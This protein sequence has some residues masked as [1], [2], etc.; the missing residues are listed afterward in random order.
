MAPDAQQRGVAVVANLAPTLPWKAVGDPVRLRQIVTNLLSNAAKFTQSGEVM[1]SAKADIHDE[2][3]TWLFL[4]VKDTGIGIPQEA[5][6]RIFDAFSQE[7]GS[8]TRRYGGTGLGLAIVRELL[9]AMGGSIEL[10]SIPGLG[11][12]FRLALPLGLAATGRDSGLAIDPVHKPSRVELRLANATLTSSIQSYLET[13]QVPCHVCAGD[14]GN[15]Q[16]AAAA[17]SLSVVDY[18]TLT[19]ACISKLAAGNAL[20]GGQ[21]TIVL[22]PFHALP[23]LEACRGNPL[24]IPLPLP[25]RMADF[26]L[27]LELG[28]QARGKTAI[29]H[30]LEGGG[31][32]FQGRVLL[33]EDHPTNQ[34]V[35]QAMLESL[36]LEVLTAGN[37]HQALEVLEASP[38]DLVLMDCHMPDMDGYEATVHIRNLERQGGGGRRL[39]IIAITA[40]ALSQ[41]R[42]RCLAVGMDDYL[43]KPVLGKDLE[44]MLARWLP[45]R[46]LEGEPVMAH[47]DDPVRDVPDAELLDQALLQELLET[48]GKAGFRRI[49]D[50][51]RE[52]TDAGLAT[53]REFLARGE[54]GDAAEL[55]H[56]LKGGSA[57]VGSRQL[58]RLCKELELQARAGQ[59]G[60]VMER[61]GEVEAAYA[62][63]CHELDALL[64]ET[65]A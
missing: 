43:A 58:P 48:L 33:V 44:R 65:Q 31:V 54:G 6:R 57:Y 15:D 28:S 49:F 30:A 41:D 16:E 8:T 13:W 55:L 10:E 26:L 2:S 25:L 53:L 42:D 23:E 29:R 21:A 17:A 9:Q 36:G 7:D 4:E 34:M 38:V 32:E 14:E 27:A 5:Q 3:A 50:K 40:N 60:T 46:P 22:A 63:L 12:I 24:V 20:P 19:P 51:F 47:A 45:A 18:A 37:G 64:A 59:L 62:R 39:P 56:K 35:L 61:L 11:S 1:L 52:T